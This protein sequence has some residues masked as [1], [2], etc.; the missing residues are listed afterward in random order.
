MNCV[1]ASPINKNKMADELRQEV[2]GG[3][4]LNSG[5][6]SETESPQTLRKSDVGN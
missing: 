2:K 1:E 6:M 3:R 5:K 4:D